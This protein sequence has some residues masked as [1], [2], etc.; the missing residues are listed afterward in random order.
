MSTISSKTLTSFKY[1][2][3][4]IFFALLSGLFY[5]LINNSSF[6][7][8]LVGILTLF[9]ALLGGILLYKATTTETKKEIFFVIGFGLIGISVFLIYYTADLI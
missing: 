1:V 8:T 7:P 4:I 5:P 9:V 6:Q 2:Y 3:L